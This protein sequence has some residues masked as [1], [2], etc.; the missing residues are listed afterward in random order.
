MPRVELV[1]RAG[2][3]AWVGLVRAEKE[4][5]V[6]PIIVGDIACRDGGPRYFSKMSYSGENYSQKEV[7]ATREEAFDAVANQAAENFLE[8]QEKILAEINKGK[9]QLKKLEKERAAFYKLREKK[10]DFSYHLKG[11]DKK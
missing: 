8:A 4:I 6:F 9:E 11:G 10:G 5:E 2:E 1:V 7:F 3:P